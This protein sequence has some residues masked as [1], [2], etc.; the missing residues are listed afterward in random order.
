M[1]FT[2]RYKIKRIILYGI[3]NDT[4]RVK[5]I[6]FWSRNR[7]EPVAGVF[8]FGVGCFLM[9]RIKPPSLAVQPAGQAV[10][11][12]P[13]ETEPAAGAHLLAAEAQNEISVAHLL[14]G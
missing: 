6:V 11:P 2:L 12:S 7:K 8:V 9:G 1:M 14:E 13:T 3:Q 10:E 5:A 4:M